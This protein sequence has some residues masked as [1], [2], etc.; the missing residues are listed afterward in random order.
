MNY[1][2]QFRPMDQVSAD[3]VTPRLV[4]VVSAMVPT[5]GIVLIVE[6]VLAIV[7]DQSVSIAN[8]TTLGRKVELGPEDLT[9]EILRVT[10]S[11]FD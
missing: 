9:V 3:R 2:G 7:I 11:V 4:V 8:P 6:V 1:T 10:D 5:K